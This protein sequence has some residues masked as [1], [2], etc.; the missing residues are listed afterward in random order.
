MDPQYENGSP[1]F[2]RGYVAG[3]VAAR[4]VLVD[5]LAE[6]LAS[7]RDDLSESKALLAALSGQPYPDD[8]EEC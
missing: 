5:E 3:L 6:W 7:T 1:E 8:E 4:R 2:K